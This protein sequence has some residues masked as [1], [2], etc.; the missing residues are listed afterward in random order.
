MNIPPYCSYIAK[1]GLKASRIM[2]YVLIR[3]LVRVQ[4]QTEFCQCAIQRALLCRLQQ[5]RRQLLPRRCRAASCVTGSLRLN[6]R[7]ARVERRPRA[8][9]VAR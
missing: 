3:I 2:L 7:E 4:F 1:G 6:S 8:Q 5:T 9:F